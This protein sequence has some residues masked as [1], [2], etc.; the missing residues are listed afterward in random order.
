MRDKAQKEDNYYKDQKY[1]KMTG[2]AAYNG[3]LVSLVGL[4]GI[5]RKGE[6]V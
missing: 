4:F 3:V 1:V 2:N 5:K 6:K